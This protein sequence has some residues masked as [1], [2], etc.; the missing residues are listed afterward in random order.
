MNNSLNL[1]KLIYVYDDIVNASNAFT[2]FC[3]IEVKDNNEY[4]LLNFTDCVTE[5]K[6]IIAEFENYLIDLIGAKQ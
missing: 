5:E 4:W 1:N 6:T 3:Q 2:E